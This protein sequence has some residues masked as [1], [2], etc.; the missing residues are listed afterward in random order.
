M[1]HRIHPLLTSAVFLTAL[2]A[3]HPAPASAEEGKKAFMEGKS[4]KKDAAKDGKEPFGTPKAVPEKET[5]EAVQVTELGLMRTLVVFDEGIDASLVKIVNQRLSDAHF[6]VFESAQR[7]TS[8][9]TDTLKAMGEKARADLV[10]HA[11]VTAREKKKFGDFSLYEGEATVKIL[12]PVNGELMVTHT[13]RATG[14]R[15]VDEVE[16]KRSATENV[17][18][19]VVKEAATKALEKSDKIIVYEVEISKVPNNLHILRIK[20]HIAKLQGVYHVRDISYDPATQIAVLEVQGSPKML[21][22]IKAH[23]EN[24]PR[25]PATK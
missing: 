17:L 11:S 3:L 21:T 15:K 23:I 20:D 4:D 7:V 9:D 16:A 12:S 25:M 2:A 18:N 13:D 10:L 5:R 1:K 22:F 24:M 8:A 19:A 6:R 14:V